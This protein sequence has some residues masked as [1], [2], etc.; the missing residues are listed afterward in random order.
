MGIWD[1]ADHIRIPLLDGSYGTGQITGS[2]GGNPTLLLTLRRTAT[3]DAPISPI[4]LAEVVSHLRTTDAALRDGLWT[5]PGFEALPHPRDSLSPLNIPD[6]TH[7]PAIVEAFLNACHGLLGWHSFPDR[8]L[9]DSML[10][11]NTK[12]PATARSGK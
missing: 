7:D 3:A 2:D 8:D 4:S 5:V 12:R 11:P 6:I 10:F 9:F 1:D